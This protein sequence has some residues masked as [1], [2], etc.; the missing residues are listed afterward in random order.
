[1][2][3]YCCLQLAR[4]KDEVG[5]IPDISNFWTRESIWKRL[6]EIRQHRKI[7]FILKFVLHSLGSG[8]SRKSLEHNKSVIMFELLRN[9]LGHVCK[10]N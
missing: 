2:I 10:M 5:Y 6:W 3:N 1:M 9:Q 4:G 7:G 8:E